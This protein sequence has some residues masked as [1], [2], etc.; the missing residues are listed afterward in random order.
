MRHAVSEKISFLNT[1][2]QQSDVQ[3]KTDKL[4]GSE[5]EA[6]RDDA[7]VAVFHGLRAEGFGASKTLARW[8]NRLLDRRH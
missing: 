2:A 4:T 1:L 3:T 5:I 7:V 8:K 6:E